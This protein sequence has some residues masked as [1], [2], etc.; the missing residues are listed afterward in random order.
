[1]S[2]NT[3]ETLKPILHIRNELE[4]EIIKLR[5]S[6]RDIDPSGL[7]LTKLKLMYCDILKFVKPYLGSSILLDKVFEDDDS[8]AKS[9]EYETESTPS[10]RTRVLQKT[11]LEDDEGDF[12]EDKDEIKKDLPNPKDKNLIFLYP[13]SK[14]TAPIDK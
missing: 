6:D 12:D 11:E 8:D 13:N 3:V 2:D 1:M 5:N 14:S 9:N 10:E 4:T 7:V